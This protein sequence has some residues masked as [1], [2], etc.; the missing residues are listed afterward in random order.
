[1]SHQQ[2][3]DAIGWTKQRAQQVEAIACLTLKTGRRR[4]PAYDRRKRY[5]ERWEATAREETPEQIEQ[6][7]ARKREYMAQYRAQTCREAAE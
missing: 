7:R 3:A 4:D 2:V 6:R 1:M 5:R